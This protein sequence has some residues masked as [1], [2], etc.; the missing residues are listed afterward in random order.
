MKRS[1]LRM[2]LGTLVLLLTLNGYAAFGQSPLDPEIEAKIK[3][4]E[5]RI[6]EEVKA[7]R[8]TQTEAKKLQDSLANIRQQANTAQSQG[9][10]TGD[11]KNQFFQMLEKNNQ[12]IESK[13]SERAKAMQQLTGQMQTV[14]SRSTK[15]Q[16]LMDERVKTNSIIPEEAA[17]LKANIENIKN[18]EG[19]LR[20]AGKLTTEEQ[21][22]L[23]KMLDANEAM[24]RD[25]KKNPVKSLFPVDQRKLGTTTK[26]TPQGKPGSGGK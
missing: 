10:M 9:K 8:L 3:S 19:R 16:N 15:Q 26:Q 22:R 18:E 2:V 20:S 4:Q 25:K 11:Q 6:Q 5:S 12:S 14:Q 23:F 7:R 21:A 13:K 1:F 17:V 24:I